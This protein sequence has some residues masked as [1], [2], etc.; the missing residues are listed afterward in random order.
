MGKKLHLST[1]TDSNVGVI[2]IKPMASAGV[3]Y[4]HNGAKKLL[5]V[6]SVSSLFKQ[7]AVVNS[8]PGT[9]QG[10]NFVLA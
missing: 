5:L 3:L 8:Y 9:Q 4:I 6:T 7:K 2:N 10:R 1:N